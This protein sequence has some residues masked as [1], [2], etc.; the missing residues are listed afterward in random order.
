MACGFYQ[1]EGFQLPHPPIPLAVFLIVEEA[2][3]ISWRR[4]TTRAGL[5]IDVHTATEDEITHDFYETLFDEV[6]GK[7]VVDGFDSER[8]DVVVREPKIRSHDRT[9]LDKMP[10][11]FVGIAGRGDIARRSQDGLFI[12]CKPVGAKHSAGR[13]YCDKGIV[14]FVRGEYAWAMTEAMMIGYVDPGCMVIPKLS[15]ALA[16]RAAALGV[17]EMPAPCPHSTVKDFANQVHT[18]HHRRLFNYAETGKPA[19]PIRLR[20]LWLVKLI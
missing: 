18:T 3:R 8:F 19:P 5:R 13:H 14:R 1:P 9:H 16:R 4:F 6:F 20:H 12:E 15:G 2:L 10:D 11:L 7:G 17:L